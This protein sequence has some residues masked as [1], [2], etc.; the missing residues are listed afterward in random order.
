MSTVM[1][2]GTVAVLQ[3]KLVQVVTEHLSAVQSSHSY[4]SQHAG[5][6]LWPTF[7]LLGYGLHSGHKGEP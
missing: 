7:V 3:D 5:T 1:Y 4:H 6:K 2:D